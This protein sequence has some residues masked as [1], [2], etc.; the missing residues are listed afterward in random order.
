MKA[1][2]PTSVD[3]GLERLA[4]DSIEDPVAWGRVS[5]EPTSVETGSERS[6]GSTVA[7][8]LRRAL[9]RAKKGDEVGAKSIL[10]D[11]WGNEQE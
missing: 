2:P 11:L 3:G 7:S 6:A 5:P 8:V 1:P 9:A 4:L 10:R